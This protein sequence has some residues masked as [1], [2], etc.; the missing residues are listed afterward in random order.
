MNF[1]LFN[2]F[3]W[4]LLFK[5]S[6]LFRKSFYQIFNF[7]GYV[8]ASN[9]VTSKRY[10]AFHF[11]DIFFLSVTNDIL[12]SIVRYDKGNITALTLLNLSLNFENNDY[13]L[14]LN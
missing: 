9:C 6:L 5:F 14:L 10:K 1:P 7:L 12:S 13:K 8:P 3:L 4:P 2:L 11:T